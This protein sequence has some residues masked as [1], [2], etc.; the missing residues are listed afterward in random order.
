MFQIHL[1]VST[2]STGWLS[3]LLYSPSPRNNWRL[4]TIYQ[5][6]LPSL[7]NINLLISIE[8]IQTS[9]LF[10]PLTVSVFPVPYNK[11]KSNKY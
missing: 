4:N 7:F 2:Y 11:Y 10:L 6:I 8:N 1:F 5:P 9:T 3:Q